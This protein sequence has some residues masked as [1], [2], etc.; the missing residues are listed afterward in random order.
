MK[1]ATETFQLAVK[2]NSFSPIGKVDLLLSCGAKSWECTIFVADIEGTY[3]L[4]LGRDSLSQLGIG[5]SLPPLLPISSPSKSD[6]EP[7]DSAAVI[8]HELI[9]SLTDNQKNYLV[10]R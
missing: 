5:I 7:S 4:A 6:N 3:D 9:E 8:P 10:Y 2:G 1:P